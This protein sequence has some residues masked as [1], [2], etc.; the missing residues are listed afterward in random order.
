MHVILLLFT[1]I[2]VNSDNYADNEY[3]YMEFS[4]NFLDKDYS[5]AIN[6]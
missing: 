6:S 1:F 3:P 2:Y 4:V 5:V